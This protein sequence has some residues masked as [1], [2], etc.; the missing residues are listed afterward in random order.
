[1]PSP[2]PDLED[3]TAEEVLA[4]AVR[5]FHPRLA[6]ACS[7]QKE[8]SVIV[9]LLLRAE[10]AARIFTLDTGLLFDETRETWR[11]F[12]ER[13]GVQVEVYAGI[14]LA[15]QAR[16]HG[17]E[18]W[19][20]DPDA[21]CDIRKVTPLEGALSTVD[22]WVSGLR[23]EQSPER[24]QTKKLAWDERHGK[25]KLNPLADWTERD[26][27]RYIAEHDLP[28][29]VLYHRGYASI[30]CTHCTRPGTGRDGRWAGEE[31]TECGLHTPGEGPA[32]AVGE[33][34]AP[35]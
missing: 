19:T 3:A 10:P 35:V 1:M 8:A 6:V 31:K 24:A 4:Y 28:Y 30:G 18:L 17:E 29:N 14:S 5:E 15:E 26:V 20:R 21:C 7:F 25:W 33:S 12:E 27:W 22:A 23:R 34:G 13:Y 11:R 32:V 9:D 16:R 2:R